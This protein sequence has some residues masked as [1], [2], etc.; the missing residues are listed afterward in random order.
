MLYHVVWLQCVCHHD[1]RV[2]LFKTIGIDEI[3]GRFNMNA[4]G[5]NER[6]LQHWFRGNKRTIGR[7][8]IA[9]TRYARRYKLR[10]DRRATAYRGQ[11]DNGFLHLG[12]AA[13]TLLQ[14][15]G[16]SLH[17]NLLKGGSDVGTQAAQRWERENAWLIVGGI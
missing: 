4:A 10:T 2:R 15:W 17:H 5:A 16:E 7:H 1:S 8:R 14:N 13:P 6:M 9:D 12:S 3:Q 11:V